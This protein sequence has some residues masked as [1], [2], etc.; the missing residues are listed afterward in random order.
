[1]SMLNLKLKGMKTGVRSSDRVDPTRDWLLLIATG[2]VLLCASLAFNLW[3]FTTA[4]ST[5][6][7]DGMGTST[8]A[9]APSYDAATEAFMQRAEEENRYRSEYRFVD[10][11]R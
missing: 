7:T 8:P 9:L 6:Q 11:S 10:P 5:K 1:M 3:L 2:F 4:L